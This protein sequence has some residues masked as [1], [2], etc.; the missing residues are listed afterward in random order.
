MDNR[1]WPGEKIRQPGNRR[2]EVARGDVRL[3]RGR[4]PERL[5]EEVGGRVVGAARPLKADIAG[6]CPR[7]S[8]EL[9]DE[10]REIRLRTR[11]GSDA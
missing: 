3:A 11:A 4:V 2:L 9:G 10:A 8:G 6:L 7:G 5:D 1:R